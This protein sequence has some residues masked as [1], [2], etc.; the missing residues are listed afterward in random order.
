MLSEWRGASTNICSSNALSPFKTCFNIPPFCGTD[1]KTD[2][3]QFASVQRPL[4]ISQT[5]SAS[6]FLVVFSLSVCPL[7][8]LSLIQTANALIQRSPFYC[9]F[10]Q[11][12]NHP[13]PCPR[14]LST[15]LMQLIANIYIKK[16]V[17]VQDACRVTQYSSL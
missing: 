7:S 4:L 15:V 3:D 16:I 11:Q 14:Y 1:I 2:S 5:K 12:Q 17:I 8:H 10:L 13:C 6:F 9:L